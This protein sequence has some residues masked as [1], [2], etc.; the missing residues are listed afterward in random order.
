[1]ENYKIEKYFF[2]DKMGKARIGFTIMN[3]FYYHE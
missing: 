3:R 2:L 1:M